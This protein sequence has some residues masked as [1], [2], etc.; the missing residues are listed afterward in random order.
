MESTMFNVGDRVRFKDEREKER[1]SVVIAIVP[2]GSYSA[3]ELGY[4]IRGSY[5][6][7]VRVAGDMELVNSDEKS[8]R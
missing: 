7:Y 4:A 3:T 5:G 1:Q 2:V 6:D 8:V